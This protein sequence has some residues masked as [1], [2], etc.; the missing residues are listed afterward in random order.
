MTEQG[1]DLI[2]PGPDHIEEILEMLVGKSIEVKRSPGAVK[3]LSQGTFSVYNYED[4]KV[5]AVIF[6]SLG[7]TNSL[8]AAIMMIPSGAAEDATDEGE[9]PK[10]LFDNY[11]EVANVMTSLM[12]DKRSHAKRVILADVYAEFDNV[13]D[14]ARAIF[15]DSTH[16]A[17]F[18]VSIAGGYPGGELYFGAA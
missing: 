14:E 9:M 2:V 11:C 17:S 3:A 7:L 8:G 5:G 13:P 1:A 6:C 4:G 18:Q 15:E 12:N 16:T 10:N